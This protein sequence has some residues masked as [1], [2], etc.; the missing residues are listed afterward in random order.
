MW[1]LRGGARCAAWRAFSAHV[2]DL[3]DLDAVV[4]LRR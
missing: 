1:T 4:V 3:L 2:R